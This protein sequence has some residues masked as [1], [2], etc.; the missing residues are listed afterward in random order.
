M[1]ETGACKQVRVQNFLRG[2]L[3]T[4]AFLMHTER[5]NICWVSNFPSS[6]VKCSMTLRYGKESEMKSQLELISLEQRKL[7]KQLIETYKYINSFNHVKNWK[8]TQ[9]LNLFPVKITR[10]W[11]QQPKNF[12][13]SSTA[14]KF[15][16]HRDKFWKANPPVS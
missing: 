3:A 10:T 13:S 2:S 15:K 7:P 14:R 12:V 1:N 11:N 16:N 5:R 9:A 8:T 6:R 4:A